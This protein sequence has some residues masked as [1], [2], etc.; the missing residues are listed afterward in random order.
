M[1]SGE[2]LAN[3][4]VEEEVRGQKLAGNRAKQEVQAKHKQHDSGLKVIEK[5]QCNENKTVPGEIEKI[6][7]RQD[8][9]RKMRSKQAR[10][11]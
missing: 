2:L 7:T 5:Q 8:E 11:E 9:E 10:E 3:P 4:S 1:S 6:K